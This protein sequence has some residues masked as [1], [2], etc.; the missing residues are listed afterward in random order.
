MLA[1]GEFCCIH[2]K[3]L[4]ENNGME[5]AF[6][7]G[8]ITDALRLLWEIHNSPE[9]GRLGEYER[10]WLD[11]C[12]FPAATF[13]YSLAQMPEPTSSKWEV[14]YQCCSRV[15]WLL[16]PVAH[17][18]YRHL[19]MD[20]RPS[21]LEVYLDAC[22]ALHCGSTDQER[23]ETISHPHKEKIKTLT[24][25]FRRLDVEAGIYLYLDV[26][27]GNYKDFYAFA[28]S[29][30]RSASELNHSLCP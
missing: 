17:G 8:Y 2:G 25:V 3:A 12:G 6:P 21:Y 22:R 23:E 1:F 29:P 13:D 16:Q 24:G 30:S 9:G 10:I 28:K 19:D 26:G 14:M 18:S 20:S 7:G 5:A 15:Q 11:K 27:D 4:E